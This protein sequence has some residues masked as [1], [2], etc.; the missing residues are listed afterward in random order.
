MLRG[1]WENLHMCCHQIV[2][3]GTGDDIGAVSFAWLGVDFSF[4]RFAVW[5]CEPGAASVETGG[6]HG[7]AARSGRYSGSSELVGEG[8]HSHVESSP[9][10]LRGPFGDRGKLR[11]GSRSSNFG[12]NTEVTAPSTTVSTTSGP[13]L[14]ANVGKYP[15]VPSSPTTVGGHPTL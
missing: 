14:G 11:C 15:R 9:V 6:L 1:I 8:G 12:S 5:E 4:R 13:T 7:V 3:P 10:F 2:I